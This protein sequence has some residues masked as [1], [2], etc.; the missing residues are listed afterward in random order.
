MST[1]PEAILKI[2]YESGGKSKAG[3]NIYRMM[4]R[5]TGNSPALMIRVKTMNNEKKELVLPVYYQDNYFSLMPGESKT[6]SITL[7]KKYL[8]GSKPS[9]YVEGWNKQTTKID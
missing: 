2:S 9:F 6:I 1:I 7:D 8:K 4:V 3:E 5:N